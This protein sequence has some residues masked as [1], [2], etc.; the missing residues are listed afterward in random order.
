MLSIRALIKALNLPVHIHYHAGGT[1]AT[2]GTIILCNP[3]LHRMKTF[4][5]T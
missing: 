5:R 3:F 1:V 4:P 2:L